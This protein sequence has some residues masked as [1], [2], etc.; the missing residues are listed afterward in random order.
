[1]SPALLGRGAT[2]FRGPT[3]DYSPAVGPSGKL[4][5]VG[6]LAD[7]AHHLGTQPG[8][9]VRAE[10]HLLGEATLS[11]HLIDGGLAEACQRLNFGH[12]QERVVVLHLCHPL[13]RG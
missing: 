3:V 5:G 8:D 2:F 7:P 6:S 4:A 12:R 13:V 1:M 11:D 10:P 9:L